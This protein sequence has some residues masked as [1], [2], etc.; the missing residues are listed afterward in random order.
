LGAM[1]FARKRDPEKST[2]YGTLSAIA[3]KQAIL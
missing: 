3:S 1:S 2:N